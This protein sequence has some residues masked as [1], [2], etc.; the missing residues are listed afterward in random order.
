MRI[1]RKHLT[2]TTQQ[3]HNKFR[4]VAIK[5]LRFNSMLCFCWICNQL[6]YCGLIQFATKQQKFHSMTL[7]NIKH[8]DIRE[9]LKSIGIN[10]Q[11]SNSRYGMYY[12]PFREDHDASLKVDYNQNLWID[13]GTGEGGSIIDLVF[14]LEN[15]SIGEAIKKLEDKS[16]SFHGDGSAPSQRESAIT[17]EKV[18]PIENLALIAYLK[19]R[20]INID[21]AKRHCHEVHYSVAGKPYFAIGFKNDSGG[22]ELRNKY[23]KGCISKDITHVQNGKITCQLFEGFMDYLSFLTIKNQQQSTADVIVLNSLTNLP[24]VEKALAGYESVALFLDNDEAG[25]RAVQN[26]RSVCKGVIDQS[27]HYISYKDLNDYLCSRSAPKQAAI[28]KPGRGMKM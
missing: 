15:C 5:L 23:F 20:S 28:R 1:N 9:Y 26:L 4:F 24:R 18:Q 21:I 8:I 17:I 7:D 3:T 11:R 13:Y 2:T 14:R 27:A 6:I 25:K 16:F 12:S 22:Y 19:E 10:P